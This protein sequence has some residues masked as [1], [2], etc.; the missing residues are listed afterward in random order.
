M[1]RRAETIGVVRYLILKGV[2]RSLANVHWEFFVPPPNGVVLFKGRV[3]ANLWPD[4]EAFEFLRDGRF[5]GKSD[6]QRTAASR[7]PVHTRG[8]RGMDVTRGASSSSYAVCFPI[9]SSDRPAAWLHAHI[10]VN[11][12]AFH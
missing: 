1:N 2:I 9:M 8:H 6:G 5:D 3:V 7:V 12:A 11:G 10:D 4:S